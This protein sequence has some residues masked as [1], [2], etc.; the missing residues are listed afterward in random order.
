MILQ[1]AADA[2]HVV[3][4]SAG[5]REA[6]VALGADAAGITVLRNGVT[7][8][9]SGRSTRRRRGGNGTCKAPPW[10]RWAR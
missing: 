6:L 10:S 2:A 8:P 5:L 1:A 4:V 7:S 9:S 3:T